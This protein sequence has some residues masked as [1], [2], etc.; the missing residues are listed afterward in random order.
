[1]LT[2]RAVDDPTLRSDE[3][4][5]RRGIRSLLCLPLMNQGA[6]QGVLYFENNQ[7]DGAFTPQRQ[8]LLR[9]LSSQAAS[10][11]EKARLNDAQKRLIEAQHKFVPVQFLQSLGHHNLFDVELGEG[12]T[13]DVDMLF[14]D[15]RK[16]TTHVE[17]M[18]PAEA[19][20]FLNNYL[21]H[22]EPVVQ[23]YGGFIDAFGGD[24]ILAL[25]ES[26]TDA[27]V[28]AAID[29]AAA[30][31]RDNEQRIR[32]GLPP[33]YTGFGINTDVVMLGI[34][35]GV[36]NLRAT[37]IG[38][39]VN[40]ASRVQELTKRYRTSMLL[41]ENTVG[42]LRLGTHLTLRPLERVQVVGKTQTIRVFEVLEALDDRQ[43]DLRQMSLQQYH[44]AI[45]AYD[46]GDF[47]TARDAFAAMV[48]A[49][50]DDSPA[51]T[52]L[53][54]VDQLIESGET[55]DGPPITRLDTK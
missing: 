30:E 48:T 4:I 10:A 37:I 14:T 3:T 20:E 9:V 36:T 7:V 17:K 8:R 19:V 53:A 5:Q 44:E 47:R 46:R 24:S 29:M 35:G 49:D 41:A 1:V 13:R 38:D 45:D 12:V 33:V 25:F 18:S 50:P 39:A 43:R 31:R 15:I 2:A 32:Q 26:G 54:R 23:Q 55:F 52:M 28:R 21:S 6:L 42:R 22:M 34:V 11:L 40:L 16:F 27:G 51:A